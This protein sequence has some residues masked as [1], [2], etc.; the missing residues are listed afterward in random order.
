MLADLL[1]AQALSEFAVAFLEL[2]DDLLGVCCL[3][4]MLSS[5]PILGDW[6]RMVGGSAHGDP[7]TPIDATRVLS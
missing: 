3:L 6:T 4:F 2:P 7:V 5:M 1:D